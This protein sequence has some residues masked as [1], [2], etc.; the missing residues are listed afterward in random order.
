MGKNK[1]K[2]FAEMETF[3]NVFQ[4]GAREMV[5]GS[6]VVAMRGVVVVV[7]VVNEGPLEQEIH[8]ISPLPLSVWSH[9]CPCMVGICPQGSPGPPLPRAILWSGGSCELTWSPL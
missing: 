7:M 4:C 5:E 6:S 2:K 8:R 9:G 1:L 3:H